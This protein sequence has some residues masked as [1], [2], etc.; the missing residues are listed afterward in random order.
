ME[1]TATHEKSQQP[2][3]SFTSYLHELVHTAF[4]SLEGY[5]D[6][7]TE[8]V[9]VNLGIAKHVIDTLEM[10]EEKTKG[11][12]TAPETNFLANSLYDLRMG[13]VRMINRHQET[14]PEETTD[15]DTAATETQ[16][17]TPTQDTAATETQ[18]AAPDQE[19][20]VTEADEADPETNTAENSDA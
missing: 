20:A 11:N 9:V 1:E 12:L 14:V 18:A 4:L 2:A 8:K 16:A 3:V 15:Q 17:E 13:Y 19:T 6:P 5:R 7:E 10:L